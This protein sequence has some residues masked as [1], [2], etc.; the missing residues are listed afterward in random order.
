[1]RRY[2]IALAILVALALM[3]AACGGANAPAQSNAPAASEPKTNSS[4]FWTKSNEGGAVTVDVT[5]TALQVGKPL[6]FEIAMNTHSVD[7]SDDL[8]KIVILRDDAGKEYAPT[9]WEGGEAGG[10]H[11]NGTLTFAAPTSKPKYV[12]LVIKGLAQVPERV[13]RWDV[14]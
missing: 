13:F 3:L 1:M 7:L 10:H 6:A 9:A 5:P 12:V 8:T 11:R 14:P 4:G 2:F